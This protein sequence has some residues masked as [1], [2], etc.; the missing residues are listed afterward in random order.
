MTLEEAIKIQED[1]ANYQ[2]RLVS[3]RSEKATRLGIEALKK[4]KQLRAWHTLPNIYP[5]S[6]ETKE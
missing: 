5:L 6:G 3:F 2:H 4:I 1:E